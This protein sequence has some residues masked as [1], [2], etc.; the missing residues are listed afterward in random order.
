MHVDMTS[1][2]VDKFREFYQGYQDETGKHIYIEQVQKMSLEGLTSIILNYDDLLRYDP[3]LARLLRENPE[4]TIK[5]A[6]D[7]LVE[8][9]RIEDP[10]YASSGEVFHARFISIPDIV[11]LRRLRSVHL[12]Q[13]ISVEGIVIR[14]SVVKPLL[15]QGVFQCAICG[16]VH[17]INQENGIYAE[18]TRCANPN[19]GKKGPFKLL[20]EE[21]TYTDLQTITVQ[22]KPESLPPGQIPRSLPSRLVGDLVDTVRAGDRA[23]AS[24]ILKMKPVF[25]K[26]KGKTAT[27][28]PWLDVNFISSREKEYEDIEIDPE[29]EK[30][31]IKLS[32]DLNI[33]RRIVRSIAPSIYGMETIKEALASVLFG[34]VSRVAPDGMKQRGDSNVLLVGDPGVAKCCQGDTKIFKV[35]G[36]M[37]TIEK[38]VNKQLKVNSHNIDDGYYAEGSLPIFTMNSLGKLEK[39]IANIFWKRRAPKTMFKVVTNLG[40]EIT[41]TPTHPFFVTKDSKLESREAKFLKVGDFIASPRRLQIESESSLNIQIKSGQSNAQNIEIPK[42]MTPELARLL[43]YLCGDGCVYKTRNSFCTSF[44]NKDKILLDDYTDC[45]EKTFKDIKYSKMN[46]TNSPLTSEIR[47][48]SIELGRFFQK[49]APSLLEGSNNKRVPTAIQRAPNELS[50]EFL[51]AYFNFDGTVGNDRCTISATSASNKLL[52][53]IQILF[54]RFGIISQLGYTHAKSQT[55][56]KRKYYRLKITSSD[57]FNKFKTVIGLDSYKGKLL[58]KSKRSNTNQDI[59]P[60][61]G[62][63]LKSIRAEMKLSQSQMGIPRSTY[64][65]YEKG[66]RNPSRASL[67][68]IVLELKKQQIS[69]KTERLEHLASSDIF[70]DQIVEIEEV[71]PNFEWVYDLQVSETHNFV[72]NGIF[73]HNSQLLQYIARLAPRGLLTSGK[74]SSAA[75]LTAAVVRDPDSGEFTLEAGALV[76]AD[77][78][79]CLTGDTEI[80]MSSGK[81]L[82]IKEIVDNDVS[83]NVVSFNPETFQVNNN[84]I[85]A[86]SKRES[87]EV[88]ELEFSTGNILKASKEH[89]LPVWNNGLS[90]KKIED[91]NINDVII[92]YRNYPFLETNS[93]DQ[94]NNKISEDFAELLGLIVSDGNLSKEKYRITFYSKSEELLQRF[95]NLTKSVYGLEIK[96]YLDKRNNVKRLYF[97]DK[98]VHQSLVK[99]GI[100]NINKSKSACIIPE[101]LNSSKQVINSFLTGIINGDGAVS[102]RKYGGIID[103]VC[104]NKETAIFYSKLFRKIG[105]IAKVTKITQLGGGVVPK[106]IYS[107]FK[108]SITGVAN[109]QKLEHTRLIS[110][111]K[112]NYEKIIERQDKSDK[113]QKI[114]KLIYS[115]SDKIPHGEKYNLYGNSIRKSQLK[116]I[117]LN[118][119]ILTDVLEKLSG[120]KGVS[121]SAEY[122]LLRKIISEDVHFIK[123]TKKKK[124]ESQIVYNI[125]VAEDE[126]YFAN[127]IPVHNCLIDEFDKMNPVDRSSIHEAM[128]Q[129]SYHPNFELSLLNGRRERIGHFV[130]DLFDQFEELKI[131]GNNCEI[132]PIN[133]LKIKAITTDFNNIFDT[134]INRVSRHTAPDHFH[135]ITFSNGREIL[136]TPEHP[137]FLHEKGEIL[138]RDANMIKKGDFVPGVRHLLQKNSSSLATEFNRGRK[139]VTLPASITEDLAKFLGYYISEGYSYSGSADEVGLSNTDTEIVGNMIEC[140]E[141]TFGLTPINYVKENRTLRIISVDIYDYLKE[142]FKDMMKKSYEKRINKKIFCISEEK[143]KA[144]LKAAFEGDGSIESTSMAYSTASKGLA[145]DYQDLL[146]TIGINSRIHKDLYHYEEEGKHQ[147]YRYKIYIA[148]DSLSSFY[149]LILG[150]PKNNAKLLRMVEKSKSGRRSHDVLPPSIAHDIISSLHKLGLSYSGYFHQ[151]LSGNYGIT[152]Y[153]IKEFLEILVN[154]K[155]IIEDRINSFDNPQKLREF[156]NY[157]KMRIAPLVGISRTT[158]AKYEKMDLTNIKN[159]E[160]LKAYKNTIYGNLKK[161]QTTIGK[162]HNLMKFRWLRVKKVERIDNV[163]EFKTDWVYDVTVEPTENFISHGVVLHNTISI[164]K[165]GIVATLNARTSIIAAANPR[166]GRYEDTRPPSE[167]INLPPTILSRFDLIFV[168]KDIPDVEKDKKMARHILELRRGHITEAVEPVISMDLLRKYISYAKQQVEPALTDEAMLRIEAYYLDLRKESDETT[169]IAITPRY[170]EAIIRLSESQAR[171]ALK[172]EVTIDHVEAAINLL[173]SSLEQVGKDPVTGKVDIDFLLSGT[174]KATRSKMQTVIDLIKEESRKGSVDIVPVR[175]IKELAKE[176][177]IEE[178][179]VDKVIDQLRSNGEI[180]SPRDGYVKLA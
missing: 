143:R 165:A 80:L 35:N 82:S 126:T 89:P 48:S 16:E 25:D 100:P 147:R 109:I 110:Y 40:K 6:D 167:N 132:L 118:K 70:W 133:H 166:F 52:S 114:D 95:E 47:V 10:I 117:G 104:G 127:F 172:E 60:A 74:A 65:H 158:L 81:L 148:G 93:S 79:V 84:K 88:Y 43:G 123:I 160:L 5:S 57:E 135:K 7:A 94:K 72:A 99:L 168:I 14:Q 19:C 78:G 46:K 163:G 134:N 2:P 177:N 3:E 23:I 12:G 154:R 122:I 41:V 1:T 69:E 171:M 61:V 103:I 97:N 9:L 62:Q 17:Y 106:G 49:L 149:N 8:V 11:D 59:I 121:E 21:S 51:K 173:R 71:K 137:I 139:E 4:E 56:P 15:V 101:I 175:K 153:K 13:F 150:K 77:R 91:L 129:H 24:G 142:N 22:E 157:S 42:M 55:S 120:D 26:R 73:V 159:N 18:P 164:A 34:G 30:E 138:E 31:I 20:T 125:Q 68:N 90:W 67:K 174:T 152:L 86:K 96:E 131:I 161:V 146:L 128:E 92:D 58:E 113:I 54:T 116:T 151:H 115:I 144:F 85:I 162:I 66:D 98:E 76:L 75:G 119:R 130:D 111:K 176:N 156:V 141:N 169:A 136:V 180:Y 29:T 39:S 50:K 37:E 124:I 108:I 32:K 170:L 112:E 178:D 53:D 87:S 102:N 83:E 27:F 38:I 45:L 63:I 64:Q 140:I 36:E 155:K 179:F 145:Y 28:D 33:H 44:T 107:A 105:I